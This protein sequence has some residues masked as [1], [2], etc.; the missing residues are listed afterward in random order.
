M[1]PQEYY[2]MA[3]KRELQAMTS[4]RDRLKKALSVALDAWDKRPWL[5]RLFDRRER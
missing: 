1:D 4:E 3:C 5:S 2:H